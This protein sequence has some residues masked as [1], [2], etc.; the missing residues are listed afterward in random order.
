MDLRFQEQIFNGDSKDPASE[1]CVRAYMGLEM[2]LTLQPTFLGERSPDLWCVYR[3]PACKNSLVLA[4][5][6]EAGSPPG[7]IRAKNNQGF[8][9]P[10][11]KG[12]G[13]GCQHLLPPRTIVFI[14]LRLYPA[15]LQ[16]D[17]G[18][19]ELRFRVK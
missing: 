17:C 3:Q 14:C 18:F 7:K 4:P 1:W 9:I 6:L 11:L 2:V 12:N 13:S 16:E 10:Y 15:C 5:S 8:P 19:S